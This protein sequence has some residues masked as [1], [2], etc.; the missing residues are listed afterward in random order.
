MERLN[1]RRP[2]RGDPCQCAGCRGKLTV[3]CTVVNRGEGVRTM[4]LYCNV[5]SCKWAPEDNK[6]TIPLEFSPPRRAS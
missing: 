4:Y 2:S 6:I 1:L 3:Q 5:P